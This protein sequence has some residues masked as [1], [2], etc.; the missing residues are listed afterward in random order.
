MKLDYPE[1]EKAT[2]FAV[3]PNNPW[4]FYAVGNTVYY[5]DL[6]GHQA[7]PIHLEGE[8]ITMLK[9]NLFRGMNALPEMQRK[10]IVG[11]VKSGSG[12]NG[13][14]RT[15]DVPSVIGDEFGVPTMHDGFGTPVDVTYR[16][17]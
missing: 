4:V 9:F 2:C 11:S 15:Y 8:T 3:H 1:I 10:L 12:L 13:V 14:V 17:R 5:F 16:E 6:E 7:N